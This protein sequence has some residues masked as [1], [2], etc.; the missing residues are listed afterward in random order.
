MRWGIERGKNHFFQQEGGFKGKVRGEGKIVPLKLKVRG[1]RKK[2]TDKKM[3]N[4]NKMGLPGD[5]F[6]RGGGGRITGGGRFGGCR[7]RKSH[8]KRTEEGQALG[9][10]Q[11]GDS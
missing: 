9:Q 7:K 4:P 11:K 5:Y 8:Y 1:K 3:R 2:K 10:D 6:L